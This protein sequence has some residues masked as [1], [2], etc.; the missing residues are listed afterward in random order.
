M[1]EYID[2]GCHPNISL[3][4]FS[5]DDMQ[6]DSAR[7]ESS[8]GVLARD[9]PFKEEMSR[10]E[11][12]SFRTRELYRPRQNDRH[13]VVFDTSLYGYHTATY[14][15][16]RGSANRRTNDTIFVASI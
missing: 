7:T 1:G 2:E 15:H 9:W 4:N 5:I 11:H 14:S 10:S 3:Q 8:G 16:A 12:L 6:A 13:R